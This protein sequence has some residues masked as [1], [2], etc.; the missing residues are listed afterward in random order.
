M[1]APSFSCCVAGILSLFAL[2][3][4]RAE[5]PCPTAT[6]RIRHTLN[7][8][9]LPE[10]AKKV[11]IWFWVPDDDECQKVLDL[12]LLNAPKS[13][14]FTRDAANGHR[15]LYAEVDAPKEPVVLATEFVLR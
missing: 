12:K 9:E 1:K 3:P 10:G 2:L 4:A 6:F 11:R 13:V 8:K 15:Y 7:V 14:Q 5:P